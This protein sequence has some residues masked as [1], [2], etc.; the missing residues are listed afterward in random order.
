[1]AAELM[2]NC[3]GASCCASYCSLDAPVCPQMGTACVAFF[4][5]DTAPDGYEDVGICVLPIP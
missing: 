3:D 5:P 2:P 4:D 1:M